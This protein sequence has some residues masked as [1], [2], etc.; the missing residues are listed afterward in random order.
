[1]QQE[2]HTT[3]RHHNG[4]N[5]IPVDK[6]VEVPVE[7]TVEK[8]VTVD[9]IIEKPIT[10]VHSETKIKEIPVDRVREVLYQGRLCAK[11]A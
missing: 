7:R 9:R 4:I 5:Q 11:D 3:S 10:V 2:R 6:F 1:M 8:V